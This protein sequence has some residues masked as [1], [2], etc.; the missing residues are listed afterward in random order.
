ML[1]RLCL[2]LV[3]LTSSALM[4]APGRAMPLAVMADI[5]LGPA[6]P[7]ESRY[8][9]AVVRTVRGMIEYTRWPQHNDPLVLCVAGPTQHAGQ[10]GSIRLSDGRRVDRRNVNATPGAL[11]GCHILYLGNLAIALQRQLTEAVRGRGVLTI[12]EADPSNAAEAMFAFTYKP[13]GLS[14]RL[15]VDAVSRS[16]LRVDPRVLRLS[17]GGA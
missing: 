8:A 3:L 6:I 4:T 16:G 1:K 14:F 2:A 7:G 10:I 17:Q 9:G 12:A 13:N 5:P 15:N 11:G